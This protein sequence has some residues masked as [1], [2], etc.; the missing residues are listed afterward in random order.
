[1]GQSM[2]L[3]AEELL[4][5]ALHATNHDEPEKAVVHL[6]RLLQIEPENAQALYLLGALHAEIGMH[7]QAETEMSKALEID[8]KLFT[9]RFQLGLLQLTSG[10]IDAATKTWEALDALG[11]THAFYL[12]K[13]GMLHLVRDEFASCVEAI[14]AG[15]A[16]N[17]F[18]EDLNNDMR[19]VMADAENAAGSLPE[20]ASTDSSPAHN[21]LISAYGEEN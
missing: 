2:D 7:E 14:K 8:P 9:A 19:R 16:A 3:N 15:I 12:F 6:K 11:S 13:T 17:D 21:L 1:M 5:L 10:R 18:N 20:S 4:H